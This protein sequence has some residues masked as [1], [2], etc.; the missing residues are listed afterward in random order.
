MWLSEPLELNDL[1]DALLPTQQFFDQY[2]GPCE[3]GRLL[4]DR[5]D[6]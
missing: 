6:V 4:L 2:L 3:L 5:R 1:L